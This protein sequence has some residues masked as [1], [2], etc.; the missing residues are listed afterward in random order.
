MPDCE[1]KYQTIL[2][3][4]EQ[5]FGKFEDAQFAPDDDAIGAGVVQKNLDGSPAWFRMSEPTD[6]MFSHKAK[7]NEF[8]LFDEDGADANDVMQGR[9]G[10]CYYLSAIAILGDKDT[11]DKFYTVSSQEEWKKCGAFCVRFY[12][13]GKVDCVIVDDYLPVDANDKSFVFTKGR[14]E[15]EIWP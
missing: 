6:D 13:V 3:R 7:S 2:A 5:G 14:N 12:E 10:D 11:K 9:L 1:L 8:C 15:Q 4:A